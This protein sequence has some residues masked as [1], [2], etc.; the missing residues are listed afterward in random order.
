MAMSRAAKRR[1]MLGVGIL[2][3]VAL[4]AGLYSF[5]Q[6]QIRSNMET[7]LEEGLAA[8][9]RDDHAAAIDPLN[10][11]VSRDR[12]NA[13]ALLAFADSRRRIPLPNNQHLDHAL[14]ITQA[15]LNVEPESIRARELLMELYGDRG[16]WTEAR[17]AA[18]QVLEIDPTHKMAHIYRIQSLQAMGREA[19]GLEA[20]R[21]M[22]E[23][24][25]EDIEAQIELFSAMRRAGATSDELR[26]FVDGLGERP[27]DEAWIGLMRY[28]VLQTELAQSLNGSDAQAAMLQRARE[29]LE[30]L[31]GL[32]S[33]SMDQLRSVIAAIDEHA[34][35]VRSQEDARFFASLSDGILNRNLDAGALGEDLVLFAAARYW[36]QNEP[37]SAASVIVGA[38]ADLAAAPTA[39]LGWLGLTYA[40]APQEGVDSTG[41]P[42]VLRQAAA[43]A[44]SEIASREGEEAARWSAMHR[45]IV[46]LASDRPAAAL[47]PLSQIQSFPDTDPELARMHLTALVQ[48]SLG[49]TAAAA[50][51]WRQ[52]LATD[53]S[54]RI[55]RPQYARAL[56]SMGRLLDA[57]RQLWIDPNSVST[58]Y[59]LEL[60]IR[61]DEAGLSRPVGT[62]DSFELATRAGRIAPDS[63]DFKT[64]IAHAALATGRRARA[65]E[66]IDEI[67]AT[68][69]EGSPGPLVALASAIRPEDPALAERVLEYA[70]RMEPTAGGLFEM[71]RL[72]YMRDGAEAGRDLIEGAIDSAPDGVRERFELV[73]AEYLDAI[74]SEE[75]AP[76]LLELSAAHPG[77]ISTQLTVLRA[78]TPWE[79][80]DSLGPVVERLRQITGRSGSQ[81]KVYEAKRS[82]AMIEETDP[83][84][85]GKYVGVVISLS[86]IINENPNNVEA[87]DVAAAAASLA[88]DHYRAS[89]YLVSAVNAD[90][91]D[92]DRQ[93]RLIEE[94][95]RAGRMQE[96]RQRAAQF[97]S[98]TLT[99]Q[100]QL[101]QRAELLERYGLEREAALD[102]ERL[103]GIGNAVARVRR[104]GELWTEGSREEADA[105]VQAVLEESEL[106][107]IG[108]VAVALY[109]F[110]SDRRERGTDLLESMPDR[111]DAE[112][113]DEVLAQYLFRSLRD[114]QD[115]RDLLER[116]RASGSPFI[117]SAAAQAFMRFEQFELA[118]EVVE[119]GLGAHPDAPRLLD[120]RRGLAAAADRSPM[121]DLALFHGV[122]G[123]RS[124]PESEAL[125]E[126]LDQRL[127]GRISDEE[128]VERLESWRAEPDARW[129]VWQ[130]LAIV[131]RSIGRL[132]EARETLLG[133]LDTFPIE[134]G[135][136]GY[137]ATQLNQMGFIED[138]VIAARHWQSR[139]SDSFYDPD[140]Y[141]A[142]LLMQVDRP[143]EA[144]IALGPWIDRI[145]A[146]R[147]SDPNSARLLAG[148]WAAT[149]NVRDA[150]ELL[151]PQVER[152]PAQAVWYFE[153]N[154]LIES[155]SD[156]RE[157]LE[158]I[159][160]TMSAL[161]NPQAHY[162]TVLAWSSLAAASGEPSDMERVRSIGE[163]AIAG[164]AEPHLM[165]LVA[166]A[167]ARDSAGDHAGAAEL[168]TRALAL[169]PDNPSLH[170]NLAYALLSADEDLDRA[171][172]HSTRAVALASER[173]MSDREI[174]SFLDTHAQV[175]LRRGA[176]GQAEAAFRQALT[177]DPRWARGII[178]LAEALA[179]QGDS[180]GAAAQLRQLDVREVLP[181]DL[182]ARR[183]ALV[184]PASEG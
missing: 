129:D 178:G 63:I 116:A 169:S 58:T 19:E 164:E 177:V 94:L 160:P 118:G 145:R 91:G 122:L 146:D 97:A 84:A 140:R 42:A 137:V 54:W 14:T 4:G 93:F 40:A 21:R 130:T 109:Y 179:A 72:A 125:A 105:L 6:A 139:T 110:N 49:E 184:D 143:D 141:A 119:E 10:R 12:S 128:L 47:E 115:A 159:T 26:A 107:E 132:D 17:T 176:P 7:W 11:F 106:S 90:P 8:Y 181:P 85:Q 5:R 142:A 9:E 76:L 150:H 165:D 180:A 3:I 25:P 37:R 81:W 108:F 70:D 75:A 53:P 61:I 155:V 87:L 32:D 56:A 157:W 57:R 59:L 13:E 48:L 45:A 113:R 50:Q 83:E 69:G 71:A 80:P 104:A 96:A 23:V 114:E 66:L 51:I 175:Q 33:T 28:R 147:E 161:D 163:D 99:T 112:T 123:L 124:S 172:E 170:N 148:V 149:G 44:R 38:Y 131:Y 174:R 2:V 98:I 153:L 27:A 135:I 64:L 43:G 136:P 55:V 100:D 35:I 126:L 127:D 82:L 89:E 167:T 117:W 92:I 152:G 16:F 78:G 102:W 134:E 156:R 183:Q 67:L 34:T 154:A 103:S 168:F 41:A 52:V 24:L 36:K 29:L 73:L 144:L 22:A 120:L 111:I 68:D 166:A 158:R 30:G 77:D 171:Q 20:A 173:G 74:G 18:S 60:E 39:A 1:V 162:A 65:T 182:A 138:A 121:S 31:A 101:L 151:W 15:A 88:R 133:A 95:T 62:P 86:D 79:N 46:A